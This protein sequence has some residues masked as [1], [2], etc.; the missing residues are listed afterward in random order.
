MMAEDKKESESVIK[1]ILF[2]FVV[3]FVLFLTSKDILFLVIIFEAC[4]AY[5]ILCLIEKKN[6]S[7]KN[8]SF[9]ALIFFLLTCCI[10]EILL[11]SMRTETMNYIYR[12]GLIFV[13]SFGEFIFYDFFSPT[14]FC[15]AFISLSQYISGLIGS[16]LFIP[17]FS[18]ILLL[19]CLIHYYNI[20][21]EDLNH[22][23]AKF[24]K[25]I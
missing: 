11:E 6:G 1:Y 2:T 12:Y 16:N 23:I 18:W 15:T 9:F 14:L 4:F 24:I 13:L 8:G 20:H 7:L 17:W 5:L 25:S 22:I 10:I 19:I 21:K 3:L